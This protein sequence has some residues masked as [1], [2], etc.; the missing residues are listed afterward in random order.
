MDG[1]G[2]DI[3]HVPLDWADLETLSTEAWFAF[4]IGFFVYI[5]EILQL[6]ARKLLPLNKAYL[7][8]DTED[9]LWSGCMICYVNWRTR[10]L[11]FLI[12]LSF[13]EFLEEKNSFLTQTCATQPHA[14]SI[15]IAASWTDAQKSKSLT[16]KISDV[17]I[18]CR[19]IYQSPHVV[20][21][22][23]LCDG[24]YRTLSEIMVNGF[25]LNWYFHASF[26][27]GF[28]CLCV[29]QRFRNWWLTFW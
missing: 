25:R 8:G 27:G 10:N 6:Q 26:R 7:L 16:H 15:V 12:L 23:S 28:Y 4:L 1:S 21:K 29:W 3:N 24:N 14:N 9:L 2:E 20:S 13:P 22:S 5:C 19:H 18:N 17:T 11:F